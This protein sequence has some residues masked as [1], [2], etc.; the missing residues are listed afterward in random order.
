MEMAS[1]FSKKLVEAADLWHESRQES[2]VPTVHTRAYY[3]EMLLEATGRVTSLSRQVE[4]GLNSGQDIVQ[5]MQSLEDVAADTALLL[6]LLVGRER[7][8]ISE[9]VFKRLEGSVKR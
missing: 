6:T 8:L 9:K 4:T 3:A 7:T 2:A 5:P 1:R